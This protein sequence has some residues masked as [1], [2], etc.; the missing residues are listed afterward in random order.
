MNSSVSAIVPVF[1]GG[2]DFKKCL[3]SLARCS[4]P[5]GEVIV[6]VDG[7]DG[8]DYSFVTNDGFILLV[9][10][11]NSGPAV[12]RNFGAEHATGDILLFIDSDVAVQEDL[13]EKVLAG[14]DCGD[15]VSAIIGSY[16]DQPAKPDFFSQYRNLLHHFVHQNGEKNASTFWG[17]CGAVKREVFETVGG[18]LSSYRHP[19]IEDIEL[20]Y[21]MKKAGYKIRL[22]KDLQIKHLKK[23]S[24][25]SIVITDILRRAFPWSRLILEEKILPDDL[26]V[27]TKARLCVILVFL[28]ILSIPLV[29]FNRNC[30]WGGALIIVL[31]V[32]L[33]RD[34]YR[35]LYKARGVLFVLASIP[36]HWLYFFYSGLALSAA[37]IA[38]NYTVFL[39]KFR[40]MQQPK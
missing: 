17:A 12:A 5:P 9:L 32:Y 18:F 38:H 34:F 4:P 15:G 8:I 29:W 11:S 3:S 10:E 19:S 24:F 28:L 39:R 26:N 37:L 21:R 40:R 6:V 36:V 7:E 1:R 25:R 16:D 23:W 14:F 27:S 20:G 30:L 13:I 35:F 2:Q 22:D 33:N 31:L